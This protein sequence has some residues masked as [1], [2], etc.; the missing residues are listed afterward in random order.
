MYTGAVYAILLHV[1]SC[2]H[3]HNP[4]TELFLTTKELPCA[5]YCQG[6]HTHWNRPPWPGTMV[7]IC[8]S[9]FIT[10]GPGKE[11][12]TNKP[13]PTRRVWERSKGDTTSQ[14]PPRWHPSWLSNVCNTRRD[15]ESEWLARDNLES[16]PITI[17]PETTSHTT[18]QFSWVP[19]LCCSLP[20]YPFP[21]KSLAFSAHVSSDN[22]FLSVRQEPTLGPWKR[23]LFLQHNQYLKLWEWISSNKSQAKVDSLKETKGWPIKKEVWDYGVMKAKRAMFLKK[24]ENQL[25]IHQICRESIEN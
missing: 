13:P 21:M 16:N 5:S 15:P 14:N 25:L 1:D 10:G 8:E 7:T 2:N 20:E 18:E 24:E 19:L 22:S 3:H 9:Y 6:E 23:S 4:N 17:K 11:H 12:R